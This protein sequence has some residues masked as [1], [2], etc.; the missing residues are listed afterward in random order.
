MRGV[1]ATEL[2]NGLFE[3]PHFF[4]EVGLLS[5]TLRLTFLSLSEKLWGLKQEL[6]AATKV[7]GNGQH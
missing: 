2:V 7:N 5:I 3:T 1:G 6:I 4:V